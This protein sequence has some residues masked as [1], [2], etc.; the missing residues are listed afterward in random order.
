MNIQ[1]LIYRSLLYQ[2]PLFLLLQLQSSLPVDEFLAQ[3][4]NLNTVGVNFYLRQHAD[5]LQCYIPFPAVATLG[6]GC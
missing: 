3:F 4:V 2:I 6:V 5:C 1:I